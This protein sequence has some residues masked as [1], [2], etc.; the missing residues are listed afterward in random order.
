MAE[1][2]AITTYLG[3]LGALVARQQ[4]L[5]DGR[6]ARLDDRQPM[7]LADRRDA[8]EHLYSYGPV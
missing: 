7:V 2:M 1:A 4:L 3:Q 5:E 8:P 6:R